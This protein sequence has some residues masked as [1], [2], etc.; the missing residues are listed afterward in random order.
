[1]DV[2]LPLIVVSGKIRDSD[3]LSVLKAARRTT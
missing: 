3:V 1:M 2:D